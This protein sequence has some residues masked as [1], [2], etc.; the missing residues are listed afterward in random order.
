MVDSLKISVKSQRLKHTPVPAN[1]PAL[2]TL[3]QRASQ[4]RADLKLGLFDERQIRWAVETGLG[5]L[6]FHTIQIASE[7]TASPLW[8]LLQGAYLT[9]RLL[10]AEQLDAMDE[11]IEV[12]AGRVPPLTLLKGISIA[13]QHYPT[14]HLRP[15]RDIDI[16][17][18]DAAHPVVESL[19]LKLGYLRRS[20]SNL[21]AEFFE[22]YHHS[23]PFF[24]PQRGVWV[25]VHRGLFSPTSG[26]GREQI[27]SLDHVYSQVRPSEFH[28]R[29][30][31]RLSNE[32]QVVYI[33]CHWSQSFQ[34]VGG[35]VALID[36]IFLLRNTGE[37]LNWEDIGEWLGGSLAAP[38]VYLLLSYLR[39]HQLI[40]I[41]PGVFQRL[42]SGQRAFGKPHLRIMHLL[43][44][45]YIVDGKT[46][47]Y[48]HNLKNL[49]MLWESLLRPG[50]P[51]RNAML[52]FL[53]LLLPARLQTVLSR[54]KGSVWEYILLGTIQMSAGIVD[55]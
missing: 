42:S 22:S 40:D 3:L 6:L 26:L 24:H 13:S 14:P 8:P 16:L 11:V 52:A 47:R 17:V 51:L 31:A 9:A 18:D 25:E 35:M 15:L 39:S 37:K 10:T 48:T 7:D 29:K 34:T 30:V 20:K 21:P 49:E 46:V 41:K 54:L 43:V 1:P 32:L 50:P 5:P 27:F 55:A 38:H 44:D 19:L 33:A 28:G 53:K 23:M 12:C 4:G 36:I 2:I 45:R